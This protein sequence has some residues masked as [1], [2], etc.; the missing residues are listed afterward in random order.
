MRFT[1]C[2]VRLD[3][4]CNFMGEINLTGEVGRVS[5]RPCMSK[6]VSTKSS[7]LLLTADLGEVGVVGW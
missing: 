4:R 3:E 1:S 7:P 6:M 2:A 5:V